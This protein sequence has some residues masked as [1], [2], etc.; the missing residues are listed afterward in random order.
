MH[1]HRHTH[2][3]AH[4]QRERESSFSIMFK[5]VLFSTAVLQSLVDMLDDPNHA[6]ECS[7]RGDVS[8]AYRDDRE[9]FYKNAEAVTK[10][11]AEKRPSKT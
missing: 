10:K 1:T 5:T 2:T 7:V 3:H 4:P 8:A 9:R 11:Y 6:N